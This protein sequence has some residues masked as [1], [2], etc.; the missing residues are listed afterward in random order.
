MCR[1]LRKLEA[2]GHIRYRSL[3]VTLP[4]GQPPRIWGLTQKGL[5][6]ADEDGVLTQH[7]KNFKDNDD[8]RLLPHEYE[9]TQFHLRLQDLCDREGWKLYWQQAD[10]KCT[11]NPDAYFR[12]SKGDKH[13]HY[14]LEVEKSKPNAARKGKSGLVR[15]LENYY[16]YYNTAKC[17]K[18]WNFP[19][20]TVIIL[21]RNADRNLNLLEDFPDP[22]RHRMFWL[23][24]EALYKR[25]IA[26][27]I[28]QT[29]KDFVHKTYSFKDL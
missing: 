10:L 27:Q 4:N 19:R 2:Q 22:F 7:A 3:P 16:D 24:S 5:F 11:V 23:T 17:E 26:G 8:A 29:P 28:F 1:T 25:D 13:W 12:I 6:A 20:Y 21:Q 15:K 18:E 14:F 9:I